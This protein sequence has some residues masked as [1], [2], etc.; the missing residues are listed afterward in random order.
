MEV[1]KAFESILTKNHP[2]KLWVDQGSEFYN[3]TFDKLLKSK[4]IKIYHTCNEGK[5]VVV[6]RFNRT[7]TSIM[8]KYFTANNTYNYIDSLDRM[9]I[10]KQY[11]S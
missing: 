2:R 6:E 9:L 8:Y 11:Y 3:K 1:T 10:N 4:N 5:A 7:L